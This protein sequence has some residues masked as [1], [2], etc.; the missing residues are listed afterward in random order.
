MMLGA[1][2][3]YQQ[4]TIDKLSTIHQHFYLKTAGGGGGVGSETYPT[5]H[6]AMQAC[7]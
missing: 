1:I 7:K 3:D 2:T 4:I 5:M 6:N